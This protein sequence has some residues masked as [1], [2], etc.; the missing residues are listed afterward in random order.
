MAMDNP[1]FGGGF[2]AGQ[3]AY[4]WKLYEPEFYRLDF[5]IDTTG[6]MAGYAKAAHSIYFQVLGDHGFVGLFIFLGIILLS[7]LNL[8]RVKKTSTDQWTVDLAKMLQ[9][10]LLAYCAGGAALSL[11]YFDLSFA[12]FALASCLLALTNRQKKVDEDI[13]DKKELV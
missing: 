3:N 13:E 8:N 6:Y 9:V 4:L 5:I 10:S 12:I 1:F 11:P 2:K 7:Y